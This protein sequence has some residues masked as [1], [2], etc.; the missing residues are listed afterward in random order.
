MEWKE[1]W[2]DSS[3]DEILQWHQCYLCSDASTYLEQLHLMQCLLWLRSIQIFA[4]V[5]VSRLGAFDYESTQFG[6][7]QYRG[8]ISKKYNMRQKNMNLAHI[9]SSV[10]STHS[11]A[12]LLWFQSLCSRWEM[13]ADSISSFTFEWLNGHRWQGTQGK[14]VMRAA[15]VV[16]PFETKLSYLRETND[17]LRVTSGFGGPCGKLCATTG[18]VWKSNAYKDNKV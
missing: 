17:R 10:T 5:H 11:H 15:A 1:P 9:P 13:T 6:A 8:A 16:L 7:P 14:W 18:S 2:E 3:V 12:F 4:F